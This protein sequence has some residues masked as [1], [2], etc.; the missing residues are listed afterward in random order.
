MKM[1]K[2]LL[3][4][5]LC[6]SLLTGC[7]DQNMLKDVKLVM[8]TGFDLTSDGKVMSTI[9]IPSFKG[10]GEGT[11]ETVSHVVSG[12]GDTSRDVRKEINLKIS[13]EF[14]ASK[15]IVLLL[16]EEYA[17]QDIYSGLDVFYR[18]PRGS[19]V[20]NAAVVKGQAADL[21]NLPLKEKSSMSEYLNGVFESAQANTVI[22]RQTR[23]MFSDFFDP[24]TDI[25]LPLIEAQEKE[26]QIIGLAMFNGRQY[27]GHYLTLQESTLY[28][29]M[30]N[31]KSKK[32]WIKVKVDENR[33]PQRKNF[34]YINV[35]KSKRELKVTAQNPDHIS[36]NLRLDLKVEILEY[37]EDHLESE[38]KINDLNNKISQEM[39]K[40]ANQIIKK[41][42]KANSDS[43]S[44]GR[45]IIA[46]HHDTWEKINWKEEY[47]NV[48]FEVKV[49]AKITKHGI[50]N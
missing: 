5:G 11:K 39:T 24:G 28:M 2:V 27:T 14:N 34:I 48:N 42:Q 31:H 33:V 13:G 46:F 43:L 35:L 30:A 26:A 3:L 49:D 8:T 45:Q 29:L 47:P 22:P 41:M 9:T 1:S 6:V 21:L 19:L 44:I 40:K 12:K 10:G 15:L 17:K 25:I 37:S 38:G 23:P 50:F 20:A 7:W 36:V 16:G 32:A 4:A 18:D